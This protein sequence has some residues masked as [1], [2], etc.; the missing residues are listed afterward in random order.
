M[1]NLLV[2]VIFIC[3]NRK[4]DVIYNINKMVEY[5]LVNK[6]ICVDNGSYDGTDDLMKSYVN[7]KI[8]YIRL[9]RNIG[10][11]AYNIAVKYSKAD[12][13]LLLDD[14]S[15]INEDIIPKV[16]NRF[17]NDVKLGILAFSIILPSTGECITRDW[18]AG[19]VTSFW[20]CGAAV[21]RD[22]WNM[23][24]GYNKNLFL[25]TNEYDLS[26]R[27]WNL[28][29]S[30]MYDPSINAYH[31]V[32]RMNRTT[33]RLIIFTIRNDTIFVKSYFDKKYHFILLLI[34]RFT[35]FIRSIMCNSTISFFRGLLESRKIKKYIIYQPVSINIQKYYINNSRIFELP[36]N[37]LKRKFIYNSV[38]KKQNLF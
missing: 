5:R 26:I 1:N 22:V 28:G 30:V 7:N 3:Y 33:D 16:I 10:I 31:R 38:F 9:G 15:H 32:S 25:Y 12:I 23:L 37:K 4:D 19:N 36:I 21:R 2:D 17:N 8:V 29:Y 13:L 18:T 34:E 20:G 24:G 27:C 6:I 14:D 11:E 35:W